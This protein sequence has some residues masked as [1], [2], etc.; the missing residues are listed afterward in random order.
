M[1]RIFQIRAFLKESPEDNFLIHALA[2]E[3]IKEGNDI[4][5]R[6]CFEQNMAA[7]PRYIASYYH[8]GKLLER[9]GN[10]EEAIA[11]YEKGMEVAKGEGDQHAFSELRSVHEELLF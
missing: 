3:Y 2:L 5:A 4:E 11:I 7:A 10:I 1:S 6:K 8:L 9:N